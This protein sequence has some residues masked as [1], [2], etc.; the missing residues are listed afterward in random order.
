MRNTDLA[1]NPN[2]T[3]YVECCRREGD[4]LVTPSVSG[5]MTVVH[6]VHRL[7]VVKQAGYFSGGSRHR[8]WVPTRYLVARLRRVEKEDSVLSS[9]HLRDFGLQVLE[10][11]KEVEPGRKWREAVAALV[12]E[13]DAGG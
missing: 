1:R 11:L 5:E 6:E 7:L 9:Y 12:A 13:V 4:R 10:T 2:M 3:G 8:R